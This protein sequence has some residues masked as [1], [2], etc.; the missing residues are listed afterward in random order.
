MM[1]PKQ[2]CQI[3][4][5][6]I[7][8]QIKS[9]FGIVVESRALTVDHGLKNQDEQTT[10]KEYGCQFSHLTRVGLVVKLKKLYDK[11]II[12]GLV[13]SVLREFVNG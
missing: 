1:Q 13:M 11:F 8:Q 3:D 7:K 12:R 9:L 4:S 6:V 2:G 5:F 10:G